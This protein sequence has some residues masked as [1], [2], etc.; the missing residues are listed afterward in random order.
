MVWID[1]GR[2]GRGSRVMYR[3][4][5]IAPRT[6][7]LSWETDAI[8][9][10]E[11]GNE[12]WNSYPSIDVSPGAAH[13][14]WA[15][16]KTVRYRRLVRSGETWTLEPTRDTRAAGPG[17][18]WGPGIRARGDDE[19][20]IL[21]PRGRYALSTDG[22]RTWKDEPVPK[23]GPLIMK[24]PGFAVD[25]AGSAHVTFTGKVR[26]APRGWTPGKQHGAYWEM[27]YVRRKAEGG[28]EDAQSILA[29]FPEWTDRGGPDDVLSDFID[30]AVDAGGHLHVAWHGSANTRSYGHDEAFYLRRA[31]TGPGTWGP[32]GTP[33]AL[34]PIDP[35]KNEFYSYA[36]S[37][38]MDERSGVVLAAVFFNVGPKYG[39]PFDAAVRILRNGVL[40]GPVIPLTRTASDGAMTGQ[41]RTAWSTWFTVTGPRVVHDGAGRAWLDSLQTVV[42]D[43]QG[44]THFVI[45]QR[46]DVTSWVRPT[47]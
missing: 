46:L 23:P 17:E 10:S 16:G 40:E 39:G 11:A 38:S 2:P 45:Y 31:A 30:I 47:P 9:I 12:Q 34:H 19:I 32:W 35:A 27:R 22:G 21:T 7:A 36:P 4:A 37:L 15:A 26:S 29:A 28:W 20:H 42:T 33:Q 6:G 8:R 41:G 25:A 18:D 14:A 24:A 5:A 1:S 44:T 3:R 13:I 43:W